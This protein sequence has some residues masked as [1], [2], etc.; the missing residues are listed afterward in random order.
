ME[1][2]RCEKFDL[3]VFKKGS[4]VA[5]SCI[6]NSCEFMF[7]GGVPHLEPRHMFWN[8]VSSSEERIEKAKKDWKAQDKEAFPPVV[9]EREEDF[10]PL[11]E[12]NKKK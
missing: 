10:V 11:P 8:F 3:V 5:L 4:D 1:G 9:N 7:F 12:R 6:S 2:M